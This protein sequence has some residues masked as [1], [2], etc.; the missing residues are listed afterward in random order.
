M[1]NI[2]ANFRSVFH[3][4]GQGLFYTGNI[5]FRKSNNN[6]KDFN[7]IYDC[8]SKNTENI[9]YELNRFKVISH[10]HEDHINGLPYLLDNFKIHSII[11]PYFSLEERVIFS[12]LNE[13]MPFWYYEFLKNPIQ[14]LINNGVEQIVIINSGEPDK[15]ENDDYS[16][17][18]DS[19]FSKKG[20]AKINFD[21]L[22]DD[23]DLKNKLQNEICNFDKLF[24][25]NKILIKKHNGIVHISGLWL[26][27][28]FN[29]KVNNDSIDELKVCLEVIDKDIFKIIR[30]KELRKKAKICYGNLRKDEKLKN[31]NN[32]SMILMHTPI[33]ESKIK[34]IK[35]FPYQRNLLSFCLA[36]FP[37]YRKDFLKE[38]LN[39]SNCLR[40]NPSFENIFGTALT[41]DIDLK[42]RYADI[43]KHFNS[44]KNILLV[45]QIPHHGSLKNWNHNFLKE[46]DSMFNI[47]SAGKFNRYGHPSKKVFEDI[48]EKHRIPFSVDE[49]NW[50]TIKGEIKCNCRI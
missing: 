41:G 27:K 28:F 3:N 14:F 48:L 47:S 13:G 20:R 32:T 6:T 34:N 42:F 10:F 35:I 45:S 7:F 21:E 2:T 16:F 43:S 31:F 5:N 40:K 37:L 30:K 24:E 49:E 23:K 9:E 18:Q 29:N 46:F 1:E 44:F 25:D 15:W 38:Y 22:N 50:F 19:D 33:K 8:G 36:G 39:N 4:V 11:L 12:A 26:F 17:S